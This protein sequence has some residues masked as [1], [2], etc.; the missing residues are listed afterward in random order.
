MASEKR[1]S[2]FLRLPREVRDKIYAN[3]LE[4]LRDTSRH[5]WSVSKRPELAFLINPHS[6]DLPPLIKTCKQVYNELAPEVLH[7]ASMIVPPTRFSSRIGIG[8][9]GRFD[10]KRVRRLTVVIGVSSPMWISWLSFFQSVTSYDAR[11][12]LFH[13]LSQE[14]SDETTHAAT[15]LEELVVVWEPIILSP[16]TIEGGDTVGDKRAVARGEEA[17]SRAAYDAQYEWTF[18][19]HIAGLSNLKVVRLRKNY[20]KH[21]GQTLREKTSARVFCE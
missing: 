10:L 6:T 17:A 8:V 7:S 9:F 18:L 3:Y 1:D 19:G 2:T 15:E 21:W 16:I 20:P 11:R 14:Y 5:Y 13:S 12:S 4:T